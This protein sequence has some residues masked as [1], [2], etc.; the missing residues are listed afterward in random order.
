MHVPCI[1]R[2]VC[3]YGEFEMVL[4]SALTACNVAVQE[5]ERDDACSM[6]ALLP[7]GGS[8]KYDRHVCS[9]RAC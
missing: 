4:G 7:Q 2:L 5:V 3:K 6:P 9:P 8:A 1:C